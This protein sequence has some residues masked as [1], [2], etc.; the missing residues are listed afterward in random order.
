[1]GTDTCDLAATG[2][3]VPTAA[4]IGILLLLIGGAALVVARSRR[5]AG[6]AASLGVLLLVGLL[7]V[8]GSVATHPLPA[9]ASSASESLCDPSTSAT[10]PV[11]PSTP[12]ATPTPTPTPTPTATPTGTGT[13]SPTPTP[14]GSCTAEGLGWFEEEATFAGLVFGDPLTGFATNFV[15][16]GWAEQALEGPG[17]VTLVLWQHI[18]TTG[19]FYTWSPQ[20]G[21]TEHS[22][23]I[24]IDST[25]EATSTGLTWDGPRLVPTGV[26]I[27]GLSMGQMIAEAELSLPL[28]VQNDPTLNFA[29][30]TLDNQTSITIVARLVDSCGQPHERSILGTY[31]NPPPDPDPW[32]WPEFD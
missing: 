4:A 16:D 18:V 7:G 15:P 11:V 31:W 24:T 20:S 32:P 13:G 1:M 28:D 8:A 2:A 23:P 30:L 22:E 5:N 19:Y 14:S 9:G 12:T 10:L 27:T 25:V 3:S 26:T 29:N 21:Y 17:T 6:L